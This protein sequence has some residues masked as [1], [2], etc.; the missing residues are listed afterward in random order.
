MA[1]ATAR[2]GVILTC[3]SCGA[4]LG[5]SEPAEGCLTCRGSRAV[6]IADRALLVL[7]AA[8]QPLPYWDVRRLMQANGGRSVNETSLKVQLANDKRLCWA[9][10]GTYGL[11]RHGLVPW[12]R[13]LSRVGGIYLHAS[14][15]ELDLVELTFVLRYAGYRFRDLSLRNALWRGVDLGIYRGASASS[16]Y[17][18]RDSV[19]RQRAAA[20]A[21]GLRRGPL[22]YDI[23]DRATRQVDSGLRELERR[24]T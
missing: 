19:K 3:P 11:F 12:A 4:E 21:V 15:A 23:V 18:S 13:D 24:R 14:G 6:T 16:W 17:G 22:F 10:A 9:G 2:G 1:R 5:P 8:D 7:E 20:K